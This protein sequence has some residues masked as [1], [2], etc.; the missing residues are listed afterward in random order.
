MNI[1]NLKI[2]KYEINL[3]L[4]SYS[5]MRINVEADIANINGK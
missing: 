5:K 3:L 2:S 1:Q 4:R